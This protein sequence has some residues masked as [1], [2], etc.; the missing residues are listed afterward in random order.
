[1]TASRSLCLA[2]AIFTAAA[3]IAYAAFRLAGADVATAS[4]GT[5][6]FAAAAFLVGAAGI[7]IK[8]GAFTPSASA[9]TVAAGAAMTGT[10]MAASRSSDAF[11]LLFIGFFLGIGIAVFAL[12]KDLDEHASPK[13]L[14][15]A[16]AAPLLAF[17]LAFGL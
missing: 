17:L 10:M 11:G 12:M 13:L 16:A 4:I 2:A 8:A 3:L 1:M 6:V 9:A 5:S 7:R 15:A 14:L